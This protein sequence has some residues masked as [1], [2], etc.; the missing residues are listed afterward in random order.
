MRASR[1]W[2]L[3]DIVIATT[4]YLFYSGLG[5]VPKINGLSFVDWKE[6]LPA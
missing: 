6:G 2:I 3:Q 4:T 5:V 1:R